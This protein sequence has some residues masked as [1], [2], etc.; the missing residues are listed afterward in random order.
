[1]DDFSPT[2]ED[3]LKAKEHFKNNP[4][5]S[6]FDKWSVHPDHENGINGVRQANYSFIRDSVS[7]EIYALSNKDCFMNL[8]GG[9]GLVKK[10]MREDGEIFAI[11]VDDAEVTNLQE[12]E[13]GKK[14][15]INK[16]RV[17]RQDPGMKYAHVK[18]LKKKGIDPAIATREDTKKDTDIKTYTIMEWGGEDLINIL[19]RKNPSLTRT[20]KLLIGLQ[21]CQ[22]LQAAHQNGVVHGDF[23]PE[24]V[25]GTVEGNNVKL[26]LIDFGFSRILEPGEKS[27]KGGKAQ[28]TIQYVAPEILQSEYSPASDNYALGVMLAFITDLGNSHALNYYA[29][30]VE[31]SQQYLKD[32]RIL[33][34][35]LEFYEINI[36]KMNPEL[37]ETLGELFN[38]DPE[39]RPPLTEIIKYICTVLE[40]QPDLEPE[41]RDQIAF[42]KKNPHLSAMPKAPSVTDPVTGLA[43]APE[44]TSVTGPVSAPETTSVTGPVTTSATS[45]ATP[46]GSTSAF[47]PIVPLQFGSSTSIK[48]KNLQAILSI[49]IRDECQKL[50]GK[51]KEHWTHESLGWMKK[52]A[53]N[54]NTALASH[55]EISLLQQLLRDIESE[56]R[57]EPVKQ[58]QAVYYVFSKMSE[59]LK[60]QES[61]QFFNAPLKT[62]CDQKCE[63]LKKTPELQ[64]IDLQRLPLSTDL[65]TKIEQSISGKENVVPQEP[66]PGKKSN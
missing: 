38:S 46:S 66:K 59:G 16:G 62:L 12:Y 42:F 11:K 55:D 2:P 3:W 1:M 9:V 18:N 26:R 28:G 45:S 31:M 24:N 57:G 34:D 7:G 30:Y 15:G 20:Q 39:K 47:P 58:A 41:L 54:S 10:G 6:K 50:R 64:G 4:D 37:R 29:S 14:T 23:K 17:V 22:I 36:S 52:P 21:C 40:K 35:P 51:R 13:A 32:Y 65:K 63:E 19:N 5:A 25:T 27:K 49:D 8:Q 61:N 56:C 60:Q 33:L 43:S 44:T 53:I 48:D